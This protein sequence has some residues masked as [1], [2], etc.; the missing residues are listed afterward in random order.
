MTTGHS[1]RYGGGGGGA[2]QVKPAVGV[3]TQVQDISRGNDSGVFADMG[4][5]SV[6][7]NL[8]ANS[9]LWVSFS[10]AYSNTS[11]G[12]PSGFQIVLDGGVVA[13]TTKRQ[14]SWGTADPEGVDITC[15]T[16]QLSAGNHT[17]KVQ[18]TSLGGPTVACNAATA[19]SG[20][21]AWLNVLEVLKP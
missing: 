21:Q 14:T 12:S 19:A 18:W 15:L 3:A 10:A 7:L 8:Q 11:G 2:A 9:R 13:Q 6:T 17:V 4:V 1:T 16:G 20:H 5:L